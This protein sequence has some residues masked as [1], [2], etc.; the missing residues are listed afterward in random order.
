VRRIA[1]PFDAREGSIG[2]P[3]VGPL[4]NP[5]LAGRSGSD[6]IRYTG[7]PVFTSTTRSSRIRYTGCPVFTWTSRP[8]MAWYLHVSPT[9]LR[10]SRHSPRGFAPASS[11]RAWPFNA[12]PRSAGYPYA[13]AKFRT[14]SFHTLPHWMDEVAPSQDGVSYSERHTTT[15]LVKAWA[16]EVVSV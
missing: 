9:G 8:F 12:G 7:C 1:S 15:S 5:A 13:S 3:P 11:S 10:V 14:A 16:P 4:R 6:R 2:Q